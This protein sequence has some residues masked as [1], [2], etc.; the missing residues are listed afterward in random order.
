MKKILPVILC[1][2]TFQCEQGW[3]EDIIDPTIEHVEKKLFVN[4]RGH[5]SYLQDLYE[6]RNQIDMAIEEEELRLKNESD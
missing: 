3:L 6:S 2:F 5:K 1:L 4:D